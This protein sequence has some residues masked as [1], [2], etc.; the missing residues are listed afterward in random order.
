[1]PE[2]SSGPKKAETVKNQ[3]LPSER[4]ARNRNIILGIIV[5]GTLMGAVDSTIVL[6]AF[7]TITARLHSNFITSLW[8]ILAY[9]LVLAVTTTQFGRMG[10]L[11]G[12]SKMFNLGFVI[13]T[14]GSVLCGFSTTI[15]ALIAFRVVQAVGGSLV[16]SNSSAI[17]S[18]VFPREIRG[19]AFGFNALGFTVG[20][21]V[22]I[23]LGGIITTFVGWQYIFFIN[24]PIGIIAVSLGLK[25]LQDTYRAIAKIDV[26]GMLILGG[27][28][29]FVSYGATEFA[30]AGL[31]TSNIVEMVVGALLISVFL[32]Y[33]Y[34]RKSPT[35]DFAS[36]KNKVLRNS[37]AALFFTSLGYLAVVFLVIMYLQGIRALSPLNASLLLVPGYVAGS[38]L[39]PLMGRLSDKYGTRNLTTLGA[40]FLL[41]ATSVF[42]TLKVDSSLLIVIGASAVSGVGAAM[43]FPANFNAVMSNA[44][45][46]AYGSL[47]GLLRTIQNV[48]LLGSFVLAISVASATIP[49]GVAFQVF[50]GT[51]NLAGGVSRQFLTGIDAAFISAILLLLIAAILSYLGGKDTWRQTPQKGKTS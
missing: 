9:L 8:I 24:A 37:V 31:S 14:V 1:L 30:A 41:I 13:F 35:I 5:V 40:I 19:R 42:L 49:R 45:P 44:K 39:S 26:V 51:T 10:D 22:G 46:G 25:Y 17:L 47:S 48:G 2:D 12:R 23:V 28:L 7:P 34:T 6:L 50:I 20:A 43:F 16:Q 38:F 32:V 3:V 36:F 21:I 4:L 11:F 29:A 15:P 33:D 27:G 18:D